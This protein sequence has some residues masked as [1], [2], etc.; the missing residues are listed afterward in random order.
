MNVQ[1]CIPK[2]KHDVSA[3][4]RARA[5]GFPSFNEAIPELLVWIQDL[6]WPVAEPVASVL[7]N[8]GPE[9]APHIRKI[10]AG[11]DAVWKYWTI[12]LVVARS[13]PEV[14]RELLGELERLADDPN[15]DDKL[16]SVDAVAQKVLDEHLV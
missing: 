5:T 9:I 10:L 1:S 11:R 14:V 2:D 4:D 7:Q 16:E 6:N 13:T 3:V 12:V 15:S 8:A